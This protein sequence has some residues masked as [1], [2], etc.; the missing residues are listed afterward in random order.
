MSTG[1]ASRPAGAPGSVL[2]YAVIGAIVWPGPRPGGLL[3]AVQDWV[4][5]GAEGNGLPIALVLALA[6][7]GDRDRCGRQLATTAIPRP[8]EPLA[9]ASR[10]ALRAA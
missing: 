5:H 8:G 4:A 10:A 3:S 2:L 9:A 6:S 1:S 7:V